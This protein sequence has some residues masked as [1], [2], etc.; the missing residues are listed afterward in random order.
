MHQKMGCRSVYDAENRVL[1]ATNGG[2]SGTYTY[3]GKSLRVKKASGSTT[4]VYIFSGSKVIAEYD[5][6]AAPSS[7]SREYIYSASRLLAK[8]DSSGTKYYH[9]D[10]LSNRVVADSSG[11]A[12]EQFG[13]YPFGESWYNASNDKLLFTTYERD[14]ESGNDY[15]MMRSYVN[16]LGRLSS[17]DPVPGSFTNPQ[18]LGRFAYVLNDPINLID[19]WGLDPGSADPC[20]NDPNQCVS[21]SA[22]SPYIDIPYAEPWGSSGIPLLISPARNIPKPAILSLKP[23]ATNSLFSRALNWT[24]CVAKTT[25]VDTAW[26][27]VGLPVGFTV[28]TTSVM[29]AAG[30]SVGPGGT[31][32][33]GGLGFAIGVDAAP[34]LFAVGAIGG[35]VGGLGHGLISCSVGSGD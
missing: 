34:E 26:G 35:A 31:I 7:P 16:R 27:A 6:G 32:A 28:L 1:S 8:I 17:P 21:V 30:S 3:D 11:N 22:D 20:A 5:N 9:Q 13:H 29:A 14:A 12:L 23:A 4:T 33:G 2:A 10:H 24:G 25:A 15:A 18:S 19:P